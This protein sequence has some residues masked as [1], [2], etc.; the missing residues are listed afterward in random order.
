MPIPAGARLGAY[1]I[2]APLGAGAMG[3]VYKARDSRLNRFVA[4]K[5]LPAD[6]VSDPRRKQRFMQS[7]APDQKTFLFTSSASPG[8]DLMMIENFR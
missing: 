6:R 7:V 1:E 3:E 2:L 4:I 5:V 8:S